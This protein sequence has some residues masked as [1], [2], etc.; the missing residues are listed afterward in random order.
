MDRTPT[1]ILEHENK[2]F[3]T[4]IKESKA[5]ISL[6]YW[7]LHDATRI[8]LFGR[9]KSSTFLSLLLFGDF[10][11]MELNLTQMDT[12]VLII[13]ACCI[14]YWMR[15]DSLIQTFPCIISSA[16]F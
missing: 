16:Y 14:K 2:N 5:G 6:G 13:S 10:Y 1:T 4:G 3:T 8:I 11:H 15:E 9:K 7:Q 12:L